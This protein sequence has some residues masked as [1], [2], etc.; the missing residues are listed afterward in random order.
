MPLKTAG[1]GSRY[2]KKPGRHGDTKHAAQ[3]HTLLDNA[4][5][6][7][8]Q[9]VF[10]ALLAANAPSSANNDRNTMLSAATA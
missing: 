2:G 4:A 10:V 8:D 3:L 1:M 5:A 6:V 9:D 7:F